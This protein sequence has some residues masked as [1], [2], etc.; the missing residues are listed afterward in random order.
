VREIE[1]EYRMVLTLKDKR[2]QNNVA[3]VG[4]VRDEHT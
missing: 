3:G 2:T 1:L 4:E